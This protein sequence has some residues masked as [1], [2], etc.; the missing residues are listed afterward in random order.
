M[1]IHLLLLFTIVPLLELFLLIEAGKLI[2]TLATV[3]LVA[4]TGFLGVLLARS[5][6]MRILYRLKQELESG[7]LPADE[8][9][10]G[11]CILLGGAMLLTPGLLTDILGFSLLIP[12]TR[13][14][15]KNAAQR[16]FKRKMEEGAAYFYRR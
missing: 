9:L 10:D 4:S 5:Q 3:I 1:L 6:G 13:S 7:S 12:I 2:G 15:F 14:L 16:L 11:V 8:I